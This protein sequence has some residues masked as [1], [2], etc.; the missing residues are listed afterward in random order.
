MFCSISLDRVDDVMRV[1][2]SAESF[3]PRTN[4]VAN[5]VIQVSRELR[6]RNIPAMIIAPDS[7]QADHF[8]G[9]PVHR[10]RSFEIP[11]VHDVDIAFASTNSIEKAIWE[12]NPTV[13][14]L[15]SPMVLGRQVLQ[16][17]DKLDVPSVAVFQTHLSGFA[18]HYRLASV[19]FIADNII[20]KIHKQAT[21]TLAPSQ[22][23]R[24]YLETL[25]VRSARIWG[26]GVDLGLFSPAMRNEHFR[27]EHAMNKPLVGFVGRLAPEKN[28][29]ILA[30]LAKGDDVQVIV[31]GDGPDRQALM[32]LMPGAHFTGKLH[33][34]ALATAM[35]SLD[36]LVASGELETFC[37]VIQEAMA[38]GVPVVA[39]ETGGP[40]DL[41][42][43]EETGLFYAPGDMGG[44]QNQVHRLLA[45]ELL[46]ARV[47]SNGLSQVANRGWGKLTGE[48]IDHYRSVSH[49]LGI[50]EAA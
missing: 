10:V 28:V 24:E 16:V 4:G 2:I 20:R 50:R 23:S 45:D 37:Q 1:L 40:R 38:S 11:G 22:A 29:R 19:S 14:H 18:D 8:E 36:V 25:D 49:R 6:S 31:I 43:H 27:A 17:T 30:K 9:T 34:S 47:I 5:S 7:F 21:L 46:R 42:V 33:G 44:M 15:A 12:F 32:D 13:A 35:A 26:R 3:L 48:L 41:I 39:P